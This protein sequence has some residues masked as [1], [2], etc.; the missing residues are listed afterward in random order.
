[1]ALIGNRNSQGLLRTCHGAFRSHTAVPCEA[2]TLPTH[3]P[4]FPGA[5]SS[6][7]WSFW[8]EGYAAIMV[9]DTGPLRYRPYHTIED[10]SGKLDYHFLSHVVEGLEGMVSFLASS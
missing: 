7:H 5:W 3:F 6:D 8:K 1:V 2:R 4:G 10:T 9:T